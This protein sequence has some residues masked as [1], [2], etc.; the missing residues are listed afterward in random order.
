MIRDIN[1]NENDLLFLMLRSFGRICF[2]N[3]GSWNNQWFYN[4]LVFKF[5]ACFN[6]LFFS[7]SFFSPKIKENV[8]SHMTPLIAFVFL[9]RVVLLDS[10]LSFCFPSFY[11]P[12]SVYISKHPPSSSAE[13]LSPT[14]CELSQSCVFGVWQK[15][16]SE[17]F[18]SSVWRVFIRFHFSQLLSTLCQLVCEVF[19]ELAKLVRDL[20]HVFLCSWL[21]HWV[22][23]CMCRVRCHSS[24][25]KWKTIGDQ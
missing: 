18:E 23:A 9:P 5:K 25:R 4:E 14:L 20:H 13:Q 2:V 21:S 24:P 15:E 19:S 22:C 10:F 1:I 11:H 17:A 6:K 12:P 16:E 8:I 7:F 3:V